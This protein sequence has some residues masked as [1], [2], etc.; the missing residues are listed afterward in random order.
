[1]IF[2]EKAYSSYY[3]SIVLRFCI[4]VTLAMLWQNFQA[5]PA[6]NI[7][8]RIVCNE[9]AFVTDSFQLR[10]NSE[11]ALALNAYIEDYIRHNKIDSVYIS[12]SAQTSFDGKRSYNDDLSRKRS[13]SVKEHIY[14][15]YPILQQCEVRIESLGEDW[16]GFLK[17]V[18]ADLMIPF[19]EELLTIANDSAL[20]LDRKE[21][22]IRKLGKGE[23]YTYLKNYILPFQRKVVICMV[24]PALKESV[25]PALEQLPVNEPELILNNEPGKTPVPVDEPPAILKP[26]KFWAI[27]TNLLQLGIGVAN[28]GVELPIANRYSIDIPV[29]F[30]PYSIS[31]SWRMRTLSIQPE[32]RWWPGKQM[33]GHFI[34]VHAQAA[35]YN[36]SWNNDDRYQDK[37][38]KTPLW[39]AGLSYGY[40]IPIRKQWGLEFTLGCGYNHLV[41]DVFYNVENGAKYA[42]ETKNYWGITRAG[43]ALIYKFNK[44]Q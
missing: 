20:D 5:Q 26:D 10:H 38:G 19:R 18:A 7:Q 11:A 2:P 13:V 41:Y 39:G 16:E 31:N 40:A 33:R 44:Q 43:V 3:K 21:A 29:T 9:I 14:T 15:N 37:N 24:S 6:Y 1:M 34:G 23:T 35:Y 12:I 17:M 30:S 32:F 25:L 4:V 27:K 36:I 8:A 28:L 22:Q 42:T